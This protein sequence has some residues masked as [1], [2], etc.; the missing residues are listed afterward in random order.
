MYQALEKELISEKTFPN[1]FAWIDRF[2]EAYETAAK[3]NGRAEVISDR[4]AIEKILSADYFEP[5]GEIDK[6]DPLQLKKGQMVD[7]TPVD[8]GSS[9]HDKGELLSLGIREVVIK[10]VVP[11]GKGHIR[12]HFP[13]INFSIKPVQE[14]NL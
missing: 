9:H 6:V 8:S 1:V 2:R 10:K 14:A 4:E 5:E 13:R 11:N 7:I 12:V 3:E